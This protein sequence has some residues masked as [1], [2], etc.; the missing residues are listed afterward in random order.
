MSPEGTIVPGELS[1]LI[2]IG[3]WV[4]KYR[5][6]T[7]GITDSVILSHRTRL[8]G[9]SLVTFPMSLFI[10]A[11]FNRGQTW[12]RI[13]HVLFQHVLHHRVVTLKL[14]MTHHMIPVLIIFEILFRT[15]NN[16]LERFSNGCLLFGACEYNWGFQLGFQLG[17]SETLICK[18]T[19]E[20][21]RSSKWRKHGLFTQ[22]NIS[23]ATTWEF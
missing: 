13:S 2:F 23:H 1:C 18:P 21:L 6:G 4:I 11:V 5:N 10:L 14:K 22:L 9:Q 17:I 7:V 16:S 19:L 12:L 3:Q 15:I 8:C 20:S